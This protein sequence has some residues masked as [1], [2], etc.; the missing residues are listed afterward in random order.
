MIFARPAAT[1]LRD[2]DE[3]ELLR[4]GQ[5]AGLAGRAGDDD[6]VGAR[7]DDVVDVLLD[8]RPSPLRRRR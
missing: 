7:V 2:L 3:P 5:R 4:V 8:A 1:D 6:A